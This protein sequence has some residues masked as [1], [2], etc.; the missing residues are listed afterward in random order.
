MAGK[1]AHG[2]GLAPL[3]QIGVRPEDVLSEQE[4]ACV[5]APMRDYQ[6]R[7]ARRGNKP[8]E[9]AAEECIRLAALGLLQLDRLSQAADGEVDIDVDG[10]AQF[11]VTT[12]KEGL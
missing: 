7:L 5:T 12:C 6:A 10:P 3:C 9:L 2:A 8:G 1:S 11:I 4:R